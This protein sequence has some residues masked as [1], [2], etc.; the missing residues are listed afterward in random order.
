MYSS[1]H[2]GQKV[3]WFLIFVIKLETLDINPCRNETN[4]HFQKSFDEKRCFQPFHLATKQRDWP[5]VLLEVYHEKEK[6]M[7]KNVSLCCLQFLAWKEARSLRVIWIAMLSLGSYSRVVVRRKLLLR[8]KECNNNVFGTHHILK[9]YFSILPIRL[10]VTTNERMRCIICIT[11]ARFGDRSGKHQ[12][13]PSIAAPIATHK[14][15]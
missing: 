14:A 7:K 6:W 1:M 8:S 5:F 15:T 11:S 3:A 12:W 2:E 13:N 9:A 10:V 4:Y